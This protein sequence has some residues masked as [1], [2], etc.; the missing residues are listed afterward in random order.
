MSA[1]VDAGLLWPDCM[2][3]KCNGTIVGPRNRSVVLYMSRMETLRPRM[4]HFSGLGRGMDRVDKELYESTVLVYLPISSR[5]SKH[6]ETVTSY[7]GT[8]TRGLV[9][10]YK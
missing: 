6:R 10:L 7:S 1:Y 4:A 3:E 9:P 8:T 5:H 2:V